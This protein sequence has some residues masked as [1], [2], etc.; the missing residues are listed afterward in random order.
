MKGGSCKLP[1]RKQERRHLKGWDERAP[2]LRTR[3]SL[4]RSRGVPATAASNPNRARDPSARA[5]PAKC[6]RA[7]RFPSPSPWR[8]LRHRSAEREFQGESGRCETGTRGP[9]AGTSSRGR[10]EGADAGPRDHRHQQAVAGSGF[11][12]GKSRQRNRKQCSR[13]LHGSGQLLK[14]LPSCAHSGWKKKE[15]QRLILVL[16]LAIS[17]APMG[18]LEA[19][20]EEAM[21]SRRGRSRPVLEALQEEPDH[22]RWAPDGSA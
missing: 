8:L 12:A 4:R 2:S 17:E 13:L 15:G 6:A 1:E 7:P 9:A 16:E 10:E 14:L 21:A 3:G 19:S 18:C 20:K 11:S 22:T 5:P